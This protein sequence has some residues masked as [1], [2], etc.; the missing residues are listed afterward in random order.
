MKNKALGDVKDAAIHY[1]VPFPSWISGWTKKEYS[2]GDG[3]SFGLGKIEPHFAPQ[4]WGFQLQV[5]T[6]EYTGLFFLIPLLL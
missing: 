3:M 6:C 5:V 1:D 2:P 4:V